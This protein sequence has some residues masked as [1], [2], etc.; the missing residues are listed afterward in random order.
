MAEVPPQQIKRG[1]PSKR[2]ASGQTVVFGKSEN[3]NAYSIRLR[4]TK[5]EKDQK[6]AA[7]RCLVES[8]LRGKGQRKA[9][10]I[11]S[12]RELPRVADKKER[13]RGSRTQD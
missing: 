8:P 5:R 9:S 13:H 6:H 1:T 3:C 11:S 2:S 4:G 10:L 12:G 7:D